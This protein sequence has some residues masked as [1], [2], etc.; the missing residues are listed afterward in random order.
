M[1]KFQLF[2]KT[3]DDI[4]SRLASQDEY[5]ILMI[6]GLLRKLFLD[7]NRLIDQIKNKKD[8]VRF[9]VNES[10]IISSPIKPDF[11]S[12]ED[13][14]DPN[15]AV[16]GLHNQKI[17]NIDNFLKTPVMLVDGNLITVRE[18][19]KQIAHIEGAVH[20]GRPTSNK[21]TVLKECSRTFGIGGLPAGIRLLRAIA[22]VALKGLEPLKQ[23]L[24]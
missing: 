21:E 16:P 11:W 24:L 7:K 17:V 10:K 5:E 23:K 4:E 20:S 22:R 13:G 8:K 9:I 15:T 14:L 19:I 3:L 6:S 1:E 18:L 12:I 2:I